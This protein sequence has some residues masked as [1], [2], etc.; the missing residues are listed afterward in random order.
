[1]LENTP[2]VL[3][4][5]NEA[6]IC[7]LLLDSLTSQS[8]A[9]NIVSSAQ[10][11]LDIL[12]RQVFNLVLVGANLPDISGPDLLR[13]I[14]T[15][16]PAILAVMLSSINETAGAIENAKSRALTQT[17]PGNQLSP[18][19]PDIIDPSFNAIEAIALGVET[20]QDMLDIHSEKVIQQTLTLARQ[21]GFSEEKIAQWEAAK[22]A[23]KSRKVQQIID[24]LSKLV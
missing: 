22:K 14:R 15:L 21:M 17:A 18:H 20:R 11:A 8:Y 2:R 24:S 3:I 10:D 5:D 16:H 13:K 4:I 1:M 19:I 9:C 23:E 7:E 12:N 6:S